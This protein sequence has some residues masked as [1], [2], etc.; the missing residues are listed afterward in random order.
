MASVSRTS[1][2]IPHASPP[3]CVAAI[4]AA[5]APAHATTSRQPVHRRNAAAGTSAPGTWHTAQRGSY[6]RY[7]RS[8]TPGGRPRAAPNTTPAADAT[9]RLIGS[10]AP[11]GTRSG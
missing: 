9:G 4:V 7:S 10:H 3:V 8:L 2:S 11:V 6:S 1:A 5:C